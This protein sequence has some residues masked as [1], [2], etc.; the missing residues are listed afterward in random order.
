MNFGSCHLF[1]G[2]PLWTFRG[3][4][5][6]EWWSAVRSRPQFGW[7]S[8]RCGSGCPRS[9]FSKKAAATVSVLLAPS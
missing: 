6:L 1:R 7:C 2:C 3:N 5:G 8:F 4:A 9:V